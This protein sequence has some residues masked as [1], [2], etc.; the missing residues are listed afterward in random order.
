M[1]CA[2]TLL[3]GCTDDTPVS[4]VSTC[5]CDWYRA[6]N[7]SELSKPCT[8]VVLPGLI[9]NGRVTSPVQKIGLPATDRIGGND[10]P[11]LNV[12]PNLSATLPAHP[13]FGSPESCVVCHWSCWAEGEKRLY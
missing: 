10:A 4:E 11:L 8:P 2:V 6:C 13:A 7:V 9:E 1:D 12:G 5:C 3:A